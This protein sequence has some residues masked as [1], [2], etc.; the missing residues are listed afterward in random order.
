MAEFES[1]GPAGPT[2]DLDRLVRAKMGGGTYHVVPG[3]VLEL[4]MPTI[5]QVVTAEEPSGTDK[6]TS[7][8]CRVSESATITLPVVGEI[9][10]AGRSLTEIEQAVIQA[11]MIKDSR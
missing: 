7:Y 6:V 3:D 9:E 1:A 2:V 10:V 8:V 5:L 4:S 11:Q